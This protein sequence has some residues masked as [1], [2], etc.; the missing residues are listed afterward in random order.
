ME[1]VPQ[2]ASGTFLFLLLNGLL[3]SAFSQVCEDFSPRGSGQETTERNRP[4]VNSALH[5]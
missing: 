3:I 1:Q 4:H 5:H 2:A